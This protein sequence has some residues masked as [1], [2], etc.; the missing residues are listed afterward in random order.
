VVGSCK[1]GNGSSGSINCW[2]F[3][4]WLTPGFTRTELHGVKFK[5]ITTKF[6]TNDKLLID[7]M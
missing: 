3:L 5:D 7:K 1:H 4:E 6:L 2:E